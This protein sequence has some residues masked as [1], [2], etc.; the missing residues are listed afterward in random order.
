MSDIFVFLKTLMGGTKKDTE[1]QKI[2]DIVG[3]RLKNKKLKKREKRGA[4]IAVC[5]F[6]SSSIKLILSILV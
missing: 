3:L 1:I 6:A 5:Y 2:A 4:Y